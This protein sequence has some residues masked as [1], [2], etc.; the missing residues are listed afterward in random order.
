MAAAKSIPLV[1][2]VE[3]FG[4]QISVLWLKPPRAGHAHR[5]GEPRFLVI[6]GDGARYFVERDEIVSRY[7]D[8]L[9]SCDGIAPVDGGA[10]ALLETLSLA[11]GLQIKEALFDFFTDARAA[12]SKLNQTRSVST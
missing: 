11:D 7:L 4:R 10:V 12:I 8:E 5:F 2:P 1:E 6:M 9:L 3:W